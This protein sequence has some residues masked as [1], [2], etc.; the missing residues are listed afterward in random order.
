[1]G[2]NVPGNAAEARFLYSICG[3]GLPFSYQ[4][5]MTL[6]TKLSDALQS[7]IRQASSALF[8][9]LIYRAPL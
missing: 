5:Y 1:M 8:P 2:K 4:N 3:Q 6:Y 9:I 7:T